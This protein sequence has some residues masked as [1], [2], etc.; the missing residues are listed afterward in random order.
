M[1]KLLAWID[2][3]DR[4]EMLDTWIGMTA[5]RF[6]WSLA[7]DVLWYL[8]LPRKFI[9]VSLLSGLLCFAWLSRPWAKTE[10]EIHE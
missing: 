1:K 7:T 3:L 4:N 2:G 6:S 10:E 8:G 5:V 9:L